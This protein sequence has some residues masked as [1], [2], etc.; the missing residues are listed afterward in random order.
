MKDDLARSLSRTP[1]CRPGEPSDVSSVV[2]FLCF[3][4]A[5]YI[6]GQVVCVDRG[7]TITGFYQRRMIKGKKMRDLRLAWIGLSF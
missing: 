5:S 2:A 7:H 4:A 3:P 1:S 6:T